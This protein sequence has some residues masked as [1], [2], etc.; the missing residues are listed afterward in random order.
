M[1]KV[2]THIS[3]RLTRLQREAVLAWF[4]GSEQFAAAHARLVAE[5]DVA[6]LAPEDFD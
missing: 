5:Q 1:A 6:A 3:T 4:N 2:Q